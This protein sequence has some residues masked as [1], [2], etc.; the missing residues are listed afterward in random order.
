MR[1]QNKVFVLFV[2]L[3][4]EIVVIAIIVIVI[5]VDFLLFL[6]H[7][8]GGIFKFDFGLT[9]SMM[10]D[11][12]HATITRDLPCC[13]QNIVRYAFVVVT[14]V[15]LC[16]IRCAITVG[17]RQFHLNIVDAPIAFE[18]IRKIAI[19]NFSP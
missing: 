2:I 8:F 19:S 13:A 3:W 10:K 5:T 16:Q 9:R 17:R 12:R 7:F 14:M 4:H 18:S 1:L 11:E 15:P 6:A